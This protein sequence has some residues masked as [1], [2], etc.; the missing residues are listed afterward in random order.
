V[1]L[2]NIIHDFTAAGG[3]QLRVHFPVISGGA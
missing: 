2:S 1:Y 3:H